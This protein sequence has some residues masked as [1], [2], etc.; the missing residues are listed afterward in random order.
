[1]GHEAIG[2]IEAVGADVRTVK[3]GENQLRSPREP[4]ATRKIARH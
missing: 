2:V 3:R 4:W 1:M